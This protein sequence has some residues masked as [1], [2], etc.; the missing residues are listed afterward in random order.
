MKKKLIQ[1]VEDHQSLF[2][3]DHN[4]QISNEG[5]LSTIANVV[6]N[7]F[8][9]E[10]EDKKDSKN[11][12][13]EFKPGSYYEYKQILEIYKKLVDESGKL[14][15]NVGTRTE[16]TITKD[17]SDFLFGPNQTTPVTDIDG[18]IKNLEDHY[19]F[20]LSVYTK[21]KPQVKKAIT[22]FNKLEKEIESVNYNT[23]TGEEL[24]NIFSK[25][26]DDPNLNIKP[27]SLVLPEWTKYIENCE[28]ANISQDTTIKINRDKLNAVLAVAGKMLK[29][30]ELDM[31]T[32][33]YD[34]LYLGFDYTDP[35]FR[36]DDFESDDKETND[37]INKM[38]SEEFGSH[39][40]VYDDIGGLLF[41]F[42][43]SVKKL[44]VKSTQQ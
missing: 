2:A 29:D 21:L 26:K 25:Y 34:N 17:Y 10:K 39:F 11:T 38:Y 7:I 15:P 41:G 32:N 28:K 8:K 30:I 3:F 22:A 9:N 19:K 12:K 36:V 33:D 42:N 14:K 23:V 6:K 4:L 31:L 18:I 35:P 40:K 24:I 13:E 20:I 5:F 16:V 1:T 43:Q 44:I 27:G 37:F